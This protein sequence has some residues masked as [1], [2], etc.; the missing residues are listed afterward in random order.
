M[1]LSL[2]GMAMAMALLW[3]GCLL[4]VGIINLFTPSYGT[5][6]LD[7]MSSVYPG[8]HAMHTLGDVIVGALEG[9]VDG[10]IAGVLLAWLYNWVTPRIS[11]PEEHAK[12]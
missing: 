5:F 3:G 8:F 6:F 9:L 4:F 12:A 2:K 7:V 11:L 10:A 1:R